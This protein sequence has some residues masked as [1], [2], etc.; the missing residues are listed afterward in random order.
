MAIGP[1]VELHRR[2]VEAADHVGE[3]GD[4][5]VRSVAGDKAIAQS[6]PRIACHLDGGGKPIQMH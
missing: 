5:L 1:V 2:Q 6:P 3:P 4:I